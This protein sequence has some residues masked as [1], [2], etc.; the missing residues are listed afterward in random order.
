MKILANPNNAI[1]L[2]MLMKIPPKNKKLPRSANNADALSDTNTTLVP[3]NAVT[4]ICGSTEI[5]ISNNGPIELPVK[6][7]KPSNNPKRV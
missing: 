5:T 2:K 4:T 3:I 1:V 7:P 6:K